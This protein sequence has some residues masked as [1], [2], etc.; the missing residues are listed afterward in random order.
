M[1]KASKKN[2]FH[3]NPKLKDRASQLRKNMTKAEACLW[4]YQLRAG[5]MKGYKFKRQRPVLNYIADFIC[6]ELL[7]IIEVDG[8]THEF[9][10][11]KEK[12]EKRDAALSEIGFTT[13][14]FSNWEV[15]NRMADVSIAIG[16]WIDGKVSGR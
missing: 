13:L 5:M 2:Q 9:E 12:D 3:Y 11:A 1:E 16:V 7:L 6:T 4:K 10:G 8:V 15:L 14:R